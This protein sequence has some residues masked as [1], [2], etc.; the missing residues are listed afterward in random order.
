VQGRQ[1]R[2]AGAEIVHRDRY[3]HCLQATRTSVW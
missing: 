1:R 3:P 2:I